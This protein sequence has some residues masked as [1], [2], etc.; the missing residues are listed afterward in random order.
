MKSTQTMVVLTALLLAAQGARAQE[1]SCLE[2]TRES[3]DQYLNKKM[4]ELGLKPSAIPELM[5]IK[6]DIDLNITPDG[7]EKNIYV[8]GFLKFEKGKYRLVPGLGLTLDVSKHALFYVCLKIDG[9]SP[10]N[11]M[12]VIHLERSGLFTKRFKAEPVSLSIRPLGES[13]LLVGSLL[14]SLRILDSNATIVGTQEAATFESVFY[15]VFNRAISVGAVQVDVHPKYLEMTMSSQIL[16]TIDAGKVK[17]KLSF[18]S[19]WLVK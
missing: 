12:R 5:I 13:V 1:N 19:S 18:E 3:V 17:K 15:S 4:A 6:E 7:V 9:N 14:K 2:V 11:F 8:E 10:S 16:G